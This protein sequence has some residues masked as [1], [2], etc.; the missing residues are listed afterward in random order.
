MGID[1]LSL[2]VEGAAAADAGAKGAEG[3]A[4]LAPVAA[5][6]AP[7]AA[8]AGDLAAGQAAADAISAASG[9]ASPG[10]AGAA[11]LAAAAPN[12]VIPAVYPEA[13][14]LGAAGLAGL[15]GLGT[16]ASGAL[17]P[18][19]AAPSI[20]GA[21]PPTGTSPP[22]PLPQPSPMALPPNATPTAFSASSPI[23]GSGGG[24]AAALGE[25][26]I[27]T[28]VDS[29]PT[30]GPSASGGAPLDLAA[31]NAAATGATGADAASAAG[32]GGGGILDY[33]KKNPAL[34]ASLGIGAGGIVASP[35][36]SK[37]FNK[38]PQEAQL[39]QLAGQESALAAQQNNLGTTL[40]DPL[41]TGKL[42]SGAQQE[43]TN[44]LNDAISTTK[45]RYANLGLS[46]STMEADAISNIQNQSTALTFQIAQNMAT[47]G[48]AALTGA[49]NALGLEDQVY[50]AL[51]GA[52]VAQDTALKNAIA[53]FAG[54][55]AS[56]SAIAGAVSAGKSS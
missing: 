27:S 43:V 18:S 26:D 10:V 42:P 48:Q 50:T 20:A 56:G 31:P 22:V 52:Q 6:A 36:L 49:A 30:I 16:A 7:V 15:A 45:A 4:A 53:A 17:S 37:I 11:D 24:S 47:T 46:G 5:E 25:P 40:T 3:A 12:V 35:V 39:N 19:A 54:A 32:S 33:F 21:A 1:P 8:G 28:G 44:A 38:V 41:V 14:G 51:M 29:A 2:G 9:L 13:S 23:A 55:A 34:L